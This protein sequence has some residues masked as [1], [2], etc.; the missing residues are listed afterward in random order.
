M[1]KKNPTK[2]EHDD[3][4]FFFQ[5]KNIKVNK[6]ILI[7]ECNMNEITKNVKGKEVLFC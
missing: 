7:R 3:F 5:K 6:K 4:E 1:T 2:K